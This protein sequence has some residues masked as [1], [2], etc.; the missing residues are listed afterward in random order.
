MGEPPTSRPA[1][2]VFTGCDQWKRGRTPPEPERLR[3]DEERLPG[4][5]KQGTIELNVW[6][7]KSWDIPTTSGMLRIAQAR[8]PALELLSWNPGTLKLRASRHR[9]RLEF[10]SPAIDVARYDERHRFRNIGD[11]VSHPLEVVSNP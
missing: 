5:G 3:I 2:V 7:Q 10:V 4:S 11:T 6:I 9:L 8:T 1:T